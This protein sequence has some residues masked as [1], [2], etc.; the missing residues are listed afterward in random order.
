[1]RLNGR[2][3]RR[4][5]SPFDRHV[6]VKSPWATSLG[7]AIRLRI[8]ETKRLASAIPI[9]SAASSSTKATPTYISA[10]VIWTPAGSR[11]VLFGDGLVGQPHDIRAPRIDRRGDVQIGV[12]K[13]S[14]STMPRR[15]GWTRRGQGMAI[16]SPFWPASMAFC[17]GIRSSTLHIAS[18]RRSASVLRRAGEAGDPSTAARSAPLETSGSRPEMSWHIR[19]ARRWPAMISARITCA[20]K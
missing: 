7:G 19:V 20:A 18:V 4:S 11:L 13:P 10:K 5:P 12:M 8:G 17:G 2:R 9:Q 15:P 14:A 6:D 16:T 1:M 3:R